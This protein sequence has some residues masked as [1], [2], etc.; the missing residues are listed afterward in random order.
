MCSEDDIT[1]FAT[2]TEVYSLSLEQVFHNSLEFEA[3]YLMTLFVGLTSLIANITPH[4][5]KLH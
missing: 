3:V 4:H 2:I 1:P 5:Q